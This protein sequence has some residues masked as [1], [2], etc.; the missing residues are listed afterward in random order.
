MTSINAANSDDDGLTSSTERSP[1]IGQGGQTSPLLT[2]NGP[3]HSV[4]WVI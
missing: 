2:R 4:S 3:R 1:L